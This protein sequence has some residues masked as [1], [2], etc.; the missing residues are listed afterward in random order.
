MGAELQCG[1]EEGEGVMCVCSDYDAPKVYS[2]KTQLSAQGLSMRRVRS[3]H[4]PGHSV[5]VHQGALGWMG[6]GAPVSYVPHDA[7]D[8]QPVLCLWCRDTLRRRWASL[9]S[10]ASAFE[11]EQ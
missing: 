5:R 2:E 1:A 8:L 6:P 11:E 10:M 7:K 3:L 9:R 4:R